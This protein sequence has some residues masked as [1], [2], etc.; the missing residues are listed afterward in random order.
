MSKRLWT[1]KQI[2]TDESGN[3]F[4]DEASNIRLEPNVLG[5][6]A[7]QS[8]SKQVL[9]GRHYGSC[10]DEKAAGSGRP[11]GQRGEMRQIAMSKATENGGGVARQ[12]RGH[13]LGA[14]RT[15]RSHAFNLMIFQDDTLHTHG[16]QSSGFLPPRPGANSLRKARRSRIPL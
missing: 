8:L 10:Q 4:W 1:Q 3:C 16:C 15:W 9:R 13:F 12:A 7:S 5:M 6:A 14:S 2:K 11:Q